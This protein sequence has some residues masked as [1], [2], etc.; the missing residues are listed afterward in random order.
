MT[1]AIVRYQLYAI[2]MIVNRSLVYGL[3]TV[4]VIG[5]YLGIVTGL[6]APARDRLSASPLI[7]TA[8]IALTFTPAAPAKVGCG[9]AHV[10]PA[11]RPRRGGCAGRAAARLRTWTASCAPCARRCGCRV[12]RGQLRDRLVS[13]L[14]LPKTSSAEVEPL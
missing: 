4:G 2:R 10:R 13:T 12:R 6:S 11:P 9:Q 3:L 1:V 5:A 7:A 14:P 8:V